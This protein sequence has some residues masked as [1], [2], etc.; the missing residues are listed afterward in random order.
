MA[1]SMPYLF[2][3]Q[4][5]LQSLSMVSQLNNLRKAQAQE[6]ENAIA[7][8]DQYG[9]QSELQ[10]SEAATVDE[11]MDFKARGVMAA[12]ESQARGA[13]V[14]GGA[15][16]EAIQDDTKTNLNIEAARARLGY[17]MRSLSFN[18]SAEARARGAKS[19]IDYYQSQALPTIL[20]GVSNMVGSAM[21]YA[22]FRSNQ[23]RNKPYSDIPHY[24]P[25]R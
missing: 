25:S 2:G 19:K 22:S 15:S 18:Q 6:T 24:Y 10:L 23:A 21:N 12:Q 1:Q 17:G 20:G 4:M 13:G 8:I 9:Y 5:G 7:D 11:Q 16:F 3:A 14:A